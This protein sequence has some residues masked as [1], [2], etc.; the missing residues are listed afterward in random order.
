M[1][2]Q[3]PNVESIVMQRLAQSSAF[4]R[5][6]LLT[7][8]GAKKPLGVFTASADGVP[9]SRDVLTGSATD[10]TFDGLISAKYS[11]KSGYQKKAKWLFHR[12]GVAKIA[13]LKDTTNQYLW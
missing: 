2:R 13:K 9:T 5:K 1:L 3:A 7:G 11:L 6:R 8:N 10:F 4:P 12:D